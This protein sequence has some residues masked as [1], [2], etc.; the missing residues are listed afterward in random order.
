MSES[1]TWLLSGTD[2][3]INGGGWGI[4]VSPDRRLYECAD[5]AWVAFASSEPRTWRALCEALGFDDLVDTLHQW[6]DP[7]GVTER[8]ASAFRTRPAADWVAELAPHGASV[9]R[10]NRGTE[11]QDDPQVQSRGTLERVSDMLVPRSPVRVGDADGAAAGCLDRAVAA[12]CRLAVLADAGFSPGEIDDLH[13]SGVL[14]G[15]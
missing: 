15:A 13:A 4:P 14:G 5:G 3:Q 11:L 8:L 2:G 1:A 7:A 6:P 10:V 9:V 12:R